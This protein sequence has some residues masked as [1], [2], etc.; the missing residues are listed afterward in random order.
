[1]SVITLRS[2]DDA[3][4]GGTCELNLDTDKGRFFWSGIIGE[5]K[6][7]ELSSDDC[8]MLFE[9]YNPKLWK[10]IKKVKKLPDGKPVSARWMDANIKKITRGNVECYFDR[11]T[12][13]KPKGA[14]MSKS[15]SMT[16]LGAF[17]P[18]LDGYYTVPQLVKKTGLTSITIQTACRKGEIPAVQV[19]GRWRIPKEGFEKLKSLEKTRTRTAKIDGEKYYS[20]LSMSKTGAAKR[21]NFSKRKFYSRMHNI[22][23]KHPKEFVWKGSVHNKLYSEADRD[24]LIDLMRVQ[25]AAKYLGVTPGMVRRLAEDGNLREIPIGGTKWI[26]YTTAKRIKKAN[27]FKRDKAVANKKAKRRGTLRKRNIA[28]VQKMYPPELHVVPEQPISFAHI[29]S[30]LQSATAQRQFKYDGGFL[31]MIFYVRSAIGS[32]LANNTAVDGEVTEKL[33]NLPADAMPTLQVIHDKLNVIY[34]YDRKYKG[35]LRELNECLASLV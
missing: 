9:R 20:I 15:L 22:I 3:V 29:V 23:T 33:G 12:N 13:L 24:K 28:R 18:Y 25:E 19:I 1:M 26:S 7:E 30:E 27:W 2:I 4:N 6:S 31:D 32:H 8:N 14:Q 17:M 21:R 35:V 16:V 34:P 11:H 5:N 10:A